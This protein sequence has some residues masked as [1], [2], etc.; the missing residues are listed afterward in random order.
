MATLRDRLRYLGGGSA[1]PE[2]AETRDS[3]ENPSVSLYTALVGTT[4]GTLDS[5][6]G[7]SVTPERAVRVVA[8]LACVKLLAETIAALPIDIFEREGGSRNGAIIEANDDSR[9]ELLNEEPNPEMTAFAFWAY[10]VLSVC[11]WGN[12]YVWIETG[13]DGSA[14]ALWPI[15]PY[16]IRETRSPTGVRAWLIDDGGGWGSPTVALDDEIMHFRGVGLDARRG[17][18]P[19]RE[20][21]NALGIA[22]SAEDYAGRMFQS[23]G[24][25]GAVLSTEKQMTDEQF[26]TFRSRWNSSHTGLKNAHKFA[27]L[28]PGMTYEASGFD[29][30][31]LQMV[32]A[33][34]F[35][36]REIA[37]LMRIPAHMVGATGSTSFTAV[38]QQSIDFVTYTLTGWLVNFGQTIKRGM[39]G[40]T[41]DKA[42]KLFVKHDPSTLLRADSVSRARIDNVYRLAGVKTANEIRE[43]LGLPPKEG[44]DVLWQPTNVQV[45]GPDG[46]VLSPGVDAADPAAQIAGTV[47]AATA[48]GD[49][50]A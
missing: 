40:T 48:V 33:R 47:P 43:P 8:F 35:Q 15:A 34:E 31:N 44:G 49:G 16:K 13:S 36:V 37:R 24:S 45:V 10:L 42:R 25:P 1:E 4:D 30:T 50:D 21:R 27:L 29:P 18:S 23:D 9:F 19:V 46:T 5:A 14:V 11:I 12:G 20:G 26:D 39:F 38:E 2:Q 22:L 32:E 3:L 28:P 41:A 17:L 7:A 6:T